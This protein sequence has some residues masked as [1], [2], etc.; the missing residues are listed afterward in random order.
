MDT[1]SLSPKFVAKMKEKSDSR[2]AALLD[3][4]VLAAREVGYMSITAHRVAGIA[5]C[6]HGLVFVYFKNMENLRRAVMQHAVDTE[7]AEVV[8]QGIITKSHIAMRA[9]RHVKDAARSLLSAE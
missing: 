6:S 9:P 3:A 4:A 7:D 8:L 5:N 1:T 2:R